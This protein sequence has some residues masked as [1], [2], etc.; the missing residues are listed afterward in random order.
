[1]SLDSK[2]WAKR[3]HN[4]APRRTTRYFLASYKMERGKG[5][6]SAGDFR[7]PC[8]SSILLSFSPFS[9]LPAATHDAALSSEEEP[10]SFVSSPSP[11]S[12]PS[13]V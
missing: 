6:A 4:I 3:M 9:F 11:H 7:L 5:N 12:S 10:L 1:M 8:P 2:I 13:H